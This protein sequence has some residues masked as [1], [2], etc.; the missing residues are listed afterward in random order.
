VFCQTFDESLPNSPVLQFVIFVKPTIID[1]LV[2][3]YCFNFCQPFC[4]INFCRICHFR[5]IHNNLSRCPFLSSYL[6]ILPNP[7][8]LFAYPPFLPKFAICLDSPLCHLILVFAKPLTVSCT[9]PHFL[10]LVIFVEIANCQCLFC[11]LI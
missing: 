8:E 4:L 3:S 6:N 5:K 7:D 10:K 9:I 11:C 2:L 1:M